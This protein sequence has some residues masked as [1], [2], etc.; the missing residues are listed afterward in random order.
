MTPRCTELDLF[1]DGEL[2]TAPAAAFRDH[3][4]SC[5]RCQRVLLGRMQEAVA[6]DAAGA[7]SARASL[8][9]EPPPV[10][11]A[12]A[13]VAISEARR[14]AFRRRILVYA[15]PAV[16][17][18]AVLPFLW[19]KAHTSDPLALDCPIKYG[20]TRA[21]G[22]AHVGDV[23]HPI[24]SGERHRAIMVYLER[25]LRAACPGDGQC[26]EAQDKLELLVSLKEPGMYTVVALG[27]DDELP[28]PV[29]GKTLD[30][31]LAQCTRIHCERRT[32]QVED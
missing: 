10:A 22:M 29:P 27:S 16:A 20:S 8:G 3:L 9:A 15:A 32:I 12:D 5:E 28:R 21:R 17:A 1:F 11:V 13:P 30:E 31:L 25:D 4:A 7:A 24:A 26:S 6:T 19:F 2:D 23:L 18:A 14:A